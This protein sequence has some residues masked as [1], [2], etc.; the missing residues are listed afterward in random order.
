MKMYL[1]HP[2]SGLS[3]EE[4]MEYYTET[5]QFLR[6]RYGDQL[7]IMSPM[8]GKAHLR[9]EKE[10][11]AY[12]TDH[13][14]STNHHIIERDRWMVKRAD[15]VYVNLCNTEEVSIGSMME[16]AWAHDNGVYSIVSM[17]EENVHRHAFVL[18]AADLVAENHNLAMQYLMNL[19]DD[20]CLGEKWGPPVWMDAFKQMNIVDET[21]L[22]GD[23]LPSAQIIE[24]KMGARAGRAAAERLLEGV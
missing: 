19:L 2:I 22:F 5:T 6:A 20:L 13:P 21:M 8:I 24:D 10:L 9:T 12:G 16:L 15:I 7:T 11:R 4:V 14:I 17:G 18:E 1:A 23:K 3:Y